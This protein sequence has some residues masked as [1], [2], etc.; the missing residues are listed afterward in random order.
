[1]TTVRRVEPIPP[2]PKPTAPPRGA[3]RVSEGASS[4][5]PRVA[6]SSAAI[7]FRTLGVV[8][9]DGFT[10]PLLS[11]DGRYMAVQTGGVPDRATMLAR[12]GQR[13]PIASRIALYR[14]GPRAIE[15]LG[16]TEGGLVL[17]RAADARGFLVES[18]RPDGARWIGRI[19]WGTSAS[20]KNYEPEWLVQDGRV[21]AFAALGPLGELAYCARDRGTRAFDLVVRRDGRSSVLSGGGVRSF[22]LPAFSTDGARVMTIALRDGIVELAAADPTSDATL[23]QS[24]VKALVTDRGN[25]ETAMQMAVPQG[26]R[27]GVDGR[28]LIVFHPVLGTVVRWNETDGMRPVADKAYAACRLD[29]TR[30]VYLSGSAVRVA[31][32]GVTQ[33]EPGAPSVLVLEQTAVPRA[34]GAVEGDPSVLLLRPEPRGVQIVLARFLSRPQPAAA[35]D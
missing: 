16:E 13:P 2:A 7:D 21:N 19:S 14:L 26:V 11:P 23:A 18:P 33:S 24:L 35:R 9:H 8:A 17:G 27:D 30:V 32:A 22:M 20:T 28:D 15:R 31:R 29:A 3:E 25:D 4:S 12:D 6:E 1:M 5:L 34:L 10:L